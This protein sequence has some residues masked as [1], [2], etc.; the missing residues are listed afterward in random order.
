MSFFSI[1]PSL[2]LQPTFYTTLVA[3]VLAFYLVWALARQ[4]YLGAFQQFDVLAISLS[5]GLVGLFVGQLFFPGYLALPWPL[6]YAADLLR[7]P[8]TI[9][10]VF[11][12]YVV[13]AVVSWRYIRRIRYPY[14]RVMDSNVLGVA[15]V[16]L[17][18]LIGLLLI[19]TTITL[20]IVTVS[21]AI[22][23]VAL[24]VLYH[25]ADKPGLTV[26]AHLVALFSL[27]LL[28]QYLFITWQGLS[29]GVEYA[30]GGIGVLVGLAILARNLRLKVPHTTLTQLPV[31]VSQKFRETFNRTLVTKQPSKPDGSSHS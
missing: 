25:K 23:L 22:I 16:E 21:W 3:L 1:F 13:A 12:A 5:A 29:S 28:L 14:W 7:Q 4:Q 10:A 27:C 9:V 17:G 2:F 18:W 24:L 30:I 15:L 11:C 8:F 26:G 19:D 6:A 20:A 31:G